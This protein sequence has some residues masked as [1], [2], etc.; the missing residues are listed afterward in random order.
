MGWAVRSIT[1][2]AVGT[3]A[4]GLLP[5]G[6]PLGRLGIVAYAQCGGVDS[7]A[8][9]GIAPRDPLAEI[10]PPVCTGRVMAEDKGLV[11]N[12]T[13]INTP[14]GPRE[15]LGPYDIDFERQEKIEALVSDRDKIIED[16]DGMAARAATFAMLN[17][18]FAEPFTADQF[19]KLVPLQVAEWQ[20]DFFAEYETSSEAVA[21]RHVQ[22]K[23]RVER[24]AKS[25]PRSKPTTKRATR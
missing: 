16:Q 19:K 10:P 12:R 25:A 8:V 5:T 21:T 20:A 4:A 23:N 15:M 2:R 3:R 9:H 14:V 7:G 13:V 18:I 1:G 24:R 17:L 11:P 6:C 22:L